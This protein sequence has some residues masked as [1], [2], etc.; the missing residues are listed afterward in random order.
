MGPGE[1]GRIG[2]VERDGRGGVEF[3]K[4][5]QRGD[6]VEDECPED[7]EKREKGWWRGDES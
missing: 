5:A 1:L 7:L 2:G 6:G 4:L 3:Q